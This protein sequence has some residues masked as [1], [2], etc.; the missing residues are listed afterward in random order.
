[1]PV[2]VLIAI[3]AMIGLRYGVDYWQRKDKKSFLLV[4]FLGLWLFPFFWAAAHFFWHFLLTWVA[5]TGLTVYLLFSHRL[6]AGGLPPPG[7]TK[8]AYAW[9][10]GVFRLAYYSALFGI[11]TLIFDIVL[12]WFMLFAAFGHIFLAYG[13]YYGVL[14]S[15]FTSYISL[16]R[17]FDG[18]RLKGADGR[19]SVAAGCC[20]LCDQLI[21]DS[22]NEMDGTSAPTGN[23]LKDIIKLQCGHSFH[24]VCMRG[25]V[26]VGKQE[27]CPTCGERVSRKQILLNPWD[28][29]GLIWLNVLDM[30]RWILVFNPILVLFL[31]ALHKISGDPALDPHDRLHARQQG[32]ELHMLNATGSNH[33]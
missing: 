7:Y 28:K 24:E 18:Q 8:R 19:V 6:R 29:P 20:S 13:L 33:T 9:L 26:V 17:M 25:W 1:M 2:F 10:C 31:M 22:S 11:A 5:W 16:S 30:M 4:S 3:L 32:L 15:D 27:V 12:P 14:V 21:D 23:V